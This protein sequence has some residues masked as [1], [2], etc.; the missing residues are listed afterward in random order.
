MRLHYSA[1]RIHGAGSARRP[2]Q[3]RH[4]FG[5]KNGQIEH[6]EAN[7]NGEE[8]S[9]QLASNAVEADQVMFHPGSLGFVLCLRQIYTRYAATQHVNS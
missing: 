7:G 1:A 4:T 6:P 5:Q 9:V 8:P 3:R 2:R